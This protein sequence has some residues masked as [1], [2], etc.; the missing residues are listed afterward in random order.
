M[1]GILTDVTKCIGCGD[2]VKACSQRNGLP[3]IPQ[4]DYRSRDGLSGERYTSILH[5][6]KDGQTSF[7]RKQCRH[8]LEPAC[9]SACIVG[10]LQTTPEGA[11]IYDKDKCIGC[12]YCMMACPFG[13]PRYEWKSPIPFIQKCTLCYEQIKDGGSP[14][15]TA[16]CKQQATIFGD[17]DELLKIAKQRIADNPDRYINKVYGEKEVGGTS[18]LYISNVP[19]EFLAWQPDMDDKPLPDLTWAALKKVPPVA[20]GMA[21]AMAG[22]YWIIERRMQLANGEETELKETGLKETDNE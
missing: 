4:K 17:R 9:V 1:K 10:A 3:A 16:A 21:G 5:I 14:A 18:V 15:C 13:I 19:L 2:C 20:L 8:C 22:T 12:R 11:V 6:K 7:V